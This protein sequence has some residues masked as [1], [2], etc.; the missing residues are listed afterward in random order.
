[1]KRRWAIL[2]WTSLSA[3][4]G[5]S[6]MVAQFGATLWS[7]LNFSLVGLICA[8]AIAFIAMQ[9]STQVKW[10]AG[11]ALACT[12]PMALQLLQIG[13]YVRVL[14]DYYGTSAILLLGGT[15]ATAAVAIWI[16]VT[17]LVAPPR[18]PPIAP[19]RVVD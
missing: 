13:R 9:C 3:L 12:A 14:V 8:S 4:I 6:W 2:F 1:M 10:P 19:A 17:P 16:L 5:M 7:T 18:S 11:V 15:A